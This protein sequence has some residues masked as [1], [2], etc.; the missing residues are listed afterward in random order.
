MNDLIT[1]TKQYETNTNVLA[2]LKSMFKSESFSYFAGTLCINTPDLV[3]DHSYA[4]IDVKPIHLITDPLEQEIMY[5]TS[6]MYEKYKGPKCSY[7]EQAVQNIKE[8]DALEPA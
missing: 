7:Y 6:K 8:Y 3:N 2:K 5:Y 1:I 4:T